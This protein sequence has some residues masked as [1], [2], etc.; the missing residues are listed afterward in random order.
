MDF[1]I[2]GPLELTHDGHA[3]PLPP[4]KGRALLAILLLHPNEVVS[5]DLLID[6][7]WGADPPDTARNTL[8]VYVSQVRKA[9]LV[10]S[11]SPDLLLTKPPGYLLRVKPRQLD[12]KRFERLISDARRAEAELDPEAA[13]LAFR[14]AEA[15]WRGPP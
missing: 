3:L 11:A 15:L 13:V 2:L 5:T 6:G 7:I 1:R 4:A 14:Q 12:S 8:Q 10:G 9:L